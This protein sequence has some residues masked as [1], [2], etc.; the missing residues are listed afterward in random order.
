[1]KFQPSGSIDA[2]TTFYYNA[3]GKLDEIIT[4][5]ADGSISMK[6]T[7]K[8]FSDLRGERVEESAYEGGTI[9]LNKSMTVKDKNGRPVELTTYKADGTQDIKQ[10]V[11]YVSGND[12][13]EVDIFGERGELTAKII[14]IYDS[15]GVLSEQKEYA[16]DGSLANNLVFSGDVI[17]GNEYSTSELDAKGTLVNKERHVREFDSHG[18]WIKE[19]LSK[20]NLQSGSWEPTEVTNRTITYY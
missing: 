9:L 13:S 12:P 6:K 15:H 18:N 4:Y 8:V 5:K 10:T 20:R 11:A 3:D 7:L 14:F 17:H 1:M 2:K 16:G 19:T